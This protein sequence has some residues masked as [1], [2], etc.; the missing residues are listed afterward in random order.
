VPNPTP[1]VTAAVVWSND[2]G[3]NASVA[4]DATAKFDPQ[5]RL[6]ELNDPTTGKPVFEKG[7]AT[8]TA[9]DGA[10]AWGRWTDGE[11]K[12]HGTRD[13]DNGIGNGHVATLHYVVTTATPTEPAVGRFTSFASTSPTVQAHGKLAATGTVN[14][15][16][17][18]FTATLNL[19]NTGSANYLLTVPVAGQVFT[20]TGVATQTSLSTFAGVSTITSTGF[21]CVGGCTGSLG[22]NVSVIGQIAGDTGNRAGVVYGFDSRLGNVSGV[23]VFKR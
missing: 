20:L 18:N 16:S 19:Q 6:T 1:R 12:V 8:D 22:N 2:K 13:D 7:K 10:I 5:R 15:A 14:S 17:G 4:M 11:S 9:S 23:I 21:G 3:D